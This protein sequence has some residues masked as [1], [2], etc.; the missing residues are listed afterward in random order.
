MSH[1]PHADIS[2]LLLALCR[3]GVDFIVVGG[4]A[5]V[6]QGST[7]TTEDLD[8][9]HDRAPENAA[10]LLALLE[11]LDAYQRHDLAGRKLRPTAAH[12]SGKGQLNLLTSLGPLDPL[13][14]LEPGLGYA[15]LLP[16]VEEMSDGAV[17]IKV[18]DLPTLIEVKSRLGRAKDKLA[19]ADLVALLEERGE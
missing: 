4:A 14:E 13:C 3:A 8:I 7:L 19:V 11:E 5:C 16:H 10:R 9:V 12:L 17:S 18:L 15:E 6:L 2:A 1:P